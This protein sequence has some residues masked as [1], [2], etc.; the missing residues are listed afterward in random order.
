LTQEICQK[1][2][3]KRHGVFFVVDYNNDMVRQL[4]GIDDIYK[5]MM[6][7]ILLRLQPDVNEVL[8]AQQDGRLRKVLSTQL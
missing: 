1:T 8:T 7:F 4:E 2:C 3:V 5:I 6:N